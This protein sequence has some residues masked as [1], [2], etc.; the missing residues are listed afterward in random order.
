M[1]K[2]L[3]VAEMLPLIREAI[4]SGGVF[5]L[6]PKGVSMRPLLRQG[7]DGVQLCSPEGV[8][9]GDIALFRRESGEFVLHRIVDEADDGYVFCGDNQ[10]VLE[11]GIREE[12]IIAKV[13]AILREGKTTPIT[14]PRYQR[15]VKGL[16]ARRRRIRYRVTLQAIKKKIFGK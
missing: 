10:C 13:C 1:R 6:Y 14:D 9:V 7:Q 15:Y 4:D 3:T 2:E 8:T 5:P 11:D 16:S 12:Q